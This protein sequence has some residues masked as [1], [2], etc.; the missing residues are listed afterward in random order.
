MTFDGSPEDADHPDL[1]DQ[2]GRFQREAAVLP[3]LDERPAEEI[4]GYDEHGLPG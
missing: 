1:A 3:T 4:L 2:V